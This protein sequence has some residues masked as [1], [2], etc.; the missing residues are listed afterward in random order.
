MEQEQIVPTRYKS[1]IP[2]TL[3]YPVGAKVISAALLG[4]PQFSELSIEFRY[5]NQLA[6]HH[7]TTTPYRVI[8]ARFTG[9]LR[10][11]SASK[12]PEA[13][14]YYMPRW[15]IRVDAVPRPLRHLIQLKITTEALP[16]IRSWLIG[17]YHS[18]EREGG[19]GLTFSFD[20]LKTE[21]TCK[22]HASLDWQTIKVD[23]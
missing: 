8:E 20:E 10:S 5:W 21:L 13:Q 15:T 19:H 14:T 18:T 12:K 7:G 9:P 17:N 6:R 23:G 11:F 2:H 22:E 3:S 1:K 16:S 4:V